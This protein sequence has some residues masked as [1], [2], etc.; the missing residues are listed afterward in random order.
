MRVLFTFKVTEDLVR[1]RSPGFPV[2]QT[3]TY[4]RNISSSTIPHTLSVGFR[5]GRALDRTGGDRECLMHRSQSVNAS[6]CV[7]INLSTGAYKWTFRCCSG[8]N[9][10]NTGVQKNETNRNKQ[11]PP[12]KCT[13]APHILAES[14][15]VTKATTARQIDGP[16]SCDVN[17]RRRRV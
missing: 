14:H 4:F 15:S 7:F 11:L 5:L 17:V 1:P 9:W 3:A 13:F 6:R 2:A 8:R 16:S 12:S 10:S